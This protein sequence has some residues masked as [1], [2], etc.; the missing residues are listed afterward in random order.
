MALF[1]ARAAPGASIL[2]VWTVDFPCSGGVVTVAIAVKIS[3]AEPT[4]GQELVTFSLG[5]KVA[6]ERGRMRGLVFE[7]YLIKNKHLRYCI[8]E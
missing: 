5:E 2:G 4:G 7:K 6:E 1:S 8:A 3:A